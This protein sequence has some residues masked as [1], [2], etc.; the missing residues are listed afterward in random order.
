MSDKKKNSS[1]EITIVGFVEETERED[2][3]MGLQIN[4][5]DHDYQVVMDKIGKKLEHYIDEEVLV[6]GVATGTRSQREIKVNNFRLT[7]DE[8]DGDDDGYYD[9]DKD[10]FDDERYA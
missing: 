7:D 2:G 3:Q 10:F 5:G 6:T 9:E 1:K 8:G 4:D